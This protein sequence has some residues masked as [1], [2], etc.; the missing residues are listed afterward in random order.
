MSLDVL[1]DITLNINTDYSSAQASRIKTI[2]ASRSL[3]PF[4]ENTLDFQYI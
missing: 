2:F 1:E 4:K 3:N